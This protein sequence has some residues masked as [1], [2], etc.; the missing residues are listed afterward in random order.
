MS[1][2]ST[3]L[4]A[5]KEGIELNGTVISTLFFAN[6]LLLIFHTSVRGMNRLLRAVNKFCIEMEEA[7]GHQNCDTSLRQSQRFLEKFKH[8]PR[9]GSFS[10]GKISMD[11]DR[12]QR[13]KPSL[14]LRTK[15]DQGR[16]CIWGYTH[17]AG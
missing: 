15:D 12:N 8:R 11:R 7:C 6:D 2:L 3:A 1:G 16:H 10:G 13:H 4:H 14:S 9:V 5:T 17:R